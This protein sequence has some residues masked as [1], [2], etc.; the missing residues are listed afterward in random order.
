MRI[1]TRRRPLRTPAERVG[2]L[3]NADT[4]PPAVTS[5]PDELLLARALRDRDEHAFRRVFERLLSPMLRL[6]R[7]YVRTSDEAE[8]VVQETWLAALRGA[9]SFRGRASFRTWLFQIL[10]N[11]ARTRGKRS[12]RL[13]PFSQLLRSDGVNRR[14]AGVPD[15]AWRIGPANVDWAHPERQLLVGEL[16]GRIEAAMDQLPPRQREVMVLRDIEGWSSEE[17]RAALDLSQENQ[18]VLLH[19]ARARVRQLLGPYLH[20][21]LELDPPLAQMA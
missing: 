10:R 16:R 11:R 5:A 18:R 9:G 19:R 2:L 1:Q 3:P 13:M 12:A 8:D 4:P 17:V 7:V 15:E 14:E 6:A 21:G 20:E